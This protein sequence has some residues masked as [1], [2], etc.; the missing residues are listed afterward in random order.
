MHTVPGVSLIAGL[1]RPLEFIDWKQKA[2]FAYG[3]KS[4]RVQL[5]GFLLVFW[6]RVRFWASHVLPEVMLIWPEFFA[7]NLDVR[8]RFDLRAALDRYLPLSILPIANGLR[9]DT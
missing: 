8:G 2:T 6:S 7:A 5:I 3:A 4:W 9:R 1:C